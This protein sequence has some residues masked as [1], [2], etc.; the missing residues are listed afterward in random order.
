M[1][2][3][4]GAAPAFKKVF[5]CDQ[6]N[7]AALIM[8]NPYL[9]ALINVWI[10]KRILIINLSGDVSYE[11]FIAL[12]QALTRSLITAYWTTMASS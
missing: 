4:V 12:I 10:K 7:G 9:S 1:N 8:P 5:W 11:L 3:T 2:R 6:V